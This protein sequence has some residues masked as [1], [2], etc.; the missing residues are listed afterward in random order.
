MRPPVRSGTTPFFRLPRAIALRTSLS[1]CLAPFGRSVRSLVRVVI[2]AGQGPPPLATLGH[3][4]GPGAASISSGCLQGLRSFLPSV[5]RHDAPRS[6]HGCPPSG[7][8]LPSPS[9]SRSLRSLLLR[10]PSA[11]RR[12]TASDGSRSAQRKSLAASPV[13]SRSQAPSCSWLGRSLRSCRR[14]SGAFPPPLRSSRAHAPDSVGVRFL[15]LTLAVARP[16][17]SSAVA[18][19]TII[20]PHRLRRPRALPSDSRSPFHPSLRPLRA[21][22]CVTIP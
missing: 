11:L 12:P 6:R 19:A 13:A 7:A 5:V 3:H 8:S 17:G 22:L 10:A 20:A 9:A 2:Q 16:S 18:F 4:G 14:R 15:S 1:R 21:R